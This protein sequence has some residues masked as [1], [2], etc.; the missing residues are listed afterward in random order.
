MVAYEPLPSEAAAEK[1]PQ[2][3]L[4]VQHYPGPL[5]YKYMA[6]FITEFV[7]FVQG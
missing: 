7:K 2:G 1:V 3:G 5:K 6:R 4:R